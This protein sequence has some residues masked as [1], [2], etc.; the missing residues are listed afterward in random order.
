M[1][2]THPLSEF[3]RLLAHGP[4]YEKLALHG[5]LAGGLVSLF[6]GKPEARGNLG[7]AA[8]YAVAGTGLAIGG[9]FLLFQ[10]GKFVSNRSHEAVA[11]ATAGAY[12][13]GASQTCSPGSHVE[14]WG[15]P[16]AAF[17]IPDSLQPG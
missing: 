11:E 10:F 17:C 7:H 2:V 4:Y 15:Y 1:D 12:L 14:Y 6:A 16:P 3:D 8:A 5:A 13:A 9:A